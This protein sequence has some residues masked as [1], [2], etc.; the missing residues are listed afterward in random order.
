MLVPPE[1]ARQEYTV[2]LG[3]NVSPRIRF[4]VG[5][6]YLRQ[7]ERDRHAAEVDAEHHQRQRHRHQ[8]QGAALGGHGVGA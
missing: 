1:A 3:F 4:D 7:E 5:Y 2:G 6:M 8:D